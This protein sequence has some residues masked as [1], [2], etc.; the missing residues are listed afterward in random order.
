MKSAETQQVALL[1]P[2]GSGGQHPPDRRISAWAWWPIPV[3]LAV[4]VGLWVANLR[5]VCESRLAMVLLNLLF[6]WLASLCICILT[7]RGFLGS[8]RPGLLMFG[9]GSL[10]W[11]ITSLAAAVVVQRINPTITLH[12]LGVLAAA[13]CHF[14]GLLWRRRLARPRHWLVLGYAAALLTAALLV[15]AA[16]AG[17][18]PVFF[19]QGQGGTPLRQVVLLLAVALFAWVAGQLIY[20]FRRHGGAFYYWY[21]LGLALV[22]TGLVGVLLLT[23][24]GGVLGWVNRLTQYLGS[25]YLLVAALMVARETGTWMI[26]PVLLVGAA[27][28]HA[29]GTILRQPRPW[30]WEAGRY[31]LAVGLA[32]AAYALRVVLGAWVGP[33]LPAYITFYPAIMAAALLAGFGPGLLATAVAALLV[34]YWVLP[35]VGQLAIA[36]RVD[37]LGLVIF[38]AMGVAVSLFAE[39]YRRQ[40]H[41]AAAYDRQAALRESQEALR[42][43]EERYRRLFD[44]NPDGVFTVDLAGCFTLVNPAGAALSGYPAAELLHKTFMELVAPEQLAATVAEFSRGLRDL[45]PVEFE[46][47]LLR[48]D[49]QRV[50]LWIAGAPI[51]ADGRAVAAHCTARD[52]TARRQAE[53][54]LLRS[55]EQLRR[56]EEIAHLGSWEL[57]VDANRLTWSDEVY[58]IFGLEPQE[59]GATYEAFLERIHPDDRATV[60]EAYSGSRRANRDTCEVEHRIV[61][62][63]TG[64]IRIVQ[65]RCQHLRDAAGKIVR[66]RGMVHDITDRKQAEETRHQRVAA[67]LRLSE[68]EFC[69]LAEAMPQ[70][71]WATRADGWNIYFNHQWVDYT[72]LTLAESYGHGWNTPFHPEDK[73]RARDAWQRATQYHERYSLECRL[74]RHDGIYRWWLIR[75]EPMRGSDGAVLKWFGTCTDIEEIKRSE[76]ALQEAKDSLEQRVAERTAALRESEERFRSMFDRHQAVKLVI[77]PETGAIVDANVAAARFYGYSRQQL[78]ALRIEDINQLPP[79]QIAAERAKAVAEQRGYFAFP[80]RLASGEER[81]VEVYSTPV[82]THGRPLL[83]SI[84]HDITERRRVQEAL[85]ASE[86]HYRTLFTCIAEGFYVAQVLYD[87]AGQPCDYR[88]LDVNPTFVQMMGRPREQLVGRSF[89]ELIGTDFAPGWMETFRR[90][91]QTG[92]AARY[93]FYSNVHRRH[94]EVIAF[95]PVAGQFAALVA[96]VTARK[97]AQEALAAAKFTAEQASKAKDDFIAVLS[98]ELRNPLNPVLATASLLRA[99]P[100]FDADT[101]EQLEVICRNVDLEARL[102]DDLLDVTRIERGKVELHRQPIDLG[103]IIQ[104]AVEVC[105]PDIAAQKLEFALDPGPDAPYLVEADAARLQQVFWNLLKN[106]IKFTPQGGAVGIRVRR[107]EGPQGQGRKASC[108]LGATARPLDPS[109]PGPL[110]PFV[111]VEVT[112]SGIGMEPA[113]MGRIFNAFEQ[114]ERS[115][116]RQFGGLGLGL[117]ISKALVDLHG[118]TIAV[119]SAGRGQGATF[120]VRLPLCAATLPA[121]TPTTSAPPAPVRRLHILL[122]EDHGDTARIMR[123]LLSADGHDVHHAADMATALTLAGQQAFDLLLSDLG[124]PDGTGLDLM[125]ALRAR[126]ITLPAIA[127]SGYGQEKDLQESQAAGFRAHLVK[128]VSLPKLAAA[129]AQVVG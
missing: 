35:P 71:V 112:D 57:D 101:R 58:R 11:G 20:K 81:W 41:K 18:T 110:D 25:A 89:M 127:L 122:V 79:D 124:L 8:G 117:A 45:V 118:G 109:P 119:R 126:G 115:V 103:T 91:A 30:H 33:G 123:R 121:V 68:E 97:Q 84:I 113:V 65:E 100:R 86:E 63:D 53:A 29:W 108:D 2:A 129:M 96:D 104:R 88:Y 21:G 61:R 43:S 26:P 94:F 4:I 92:T 69:A 95:R 19:V 60:D 102:I 93:D 17:W 82:E 39:F 42:A 10:L 116:T 106:A 111:T 38:C 24:Q 99:D 46:T 83:Y 90:V 72:G 47:V 73:Q 31:G 5:T 23:V 28:A 22:A 14:A 48:K 44:H 56:A 9:C 3:L 105:R 16:L 6:T 128:P 87:D 49:G 40:R 32:A 64:E 70:I 36:A 15:G 34:E 1:S 27:R 66:S 78:C 67:A 37:R 52:I 75:G 54:A 77:D 120:T 7:A 12:N 59:F 51:V 80:H 107:E 62:K 50:A 55:E 76:A 13:L 114:A 74:R 125:R 85:R 98:H